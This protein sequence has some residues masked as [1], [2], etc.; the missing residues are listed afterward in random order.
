MG[1]HTRTDMKTQAHLWTYACTHRNTEKCTHILPSQGRWE[2]AEGG[3]ASP[4]A[5]DFH[6]KAPST[7]TLAPTTSDLSLYMVSTATCNRQN[8]PGWHCGHDWDRDTF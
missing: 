3:E 4:P 1:A 8:A 5:A 7:T 2:A 6:P